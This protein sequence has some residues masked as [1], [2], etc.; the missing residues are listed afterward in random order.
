[1]GKYLDLD[2]CVAGNPLAKKEL[3]ELMGEIAT[4]KGSIAA[5]DERLVKAAERA[6]IPY[7]SCDTAEHL[8]DTVIELRADLDRAREALKIC[9]DDLVEWQRTFGQHSETTDVLQK[10]QQTLRE[11]SQ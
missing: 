5:D 2:D 6:G 7:F 1:M 10:A 11:I 8:A 3:E 4:L 9:I